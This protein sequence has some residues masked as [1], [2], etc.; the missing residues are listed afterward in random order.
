VLF[1]LWCE[2]ASCFRGLVQCSLFYLSNFDLGC[3][4]DIKVPINWMKELGD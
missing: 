1:L 4:S 3:G 2:E